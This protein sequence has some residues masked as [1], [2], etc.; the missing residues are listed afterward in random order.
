MTLSLAQ[1]LVEWFPDRR[2]TATGLTIA[3]FGSGAVVATPLSGWLCQ[4]F[5]TMPQFLGAVESVEMVS[6]EGRLY[7]E[8]NG[9][10]SEVVVATK[11]ALAS[12]PYTG[13]SEG[14]YV[15]GTGNT[16]AAAALATMGACSSGTSAAHALTRLLTP[17][18]WAQVL[19]TSASWLR[20]R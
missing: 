16:G 12:L 11:D 13:L 1:A 6:K 15:V 19:A 9:T 7:S 3:G 10:L 17:G 20:Q 2:A 8:V 5:A 4:K 14:V 18:T